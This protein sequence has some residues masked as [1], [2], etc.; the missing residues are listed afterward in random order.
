MIMIKHARTH[1]HART[2]ARAHARTPAHTSFI[3]S[4][5]PKIAN[6]ISLSQGS[7]KIPLCRE[8]AV[9]M[10]DLSYHTSVNNL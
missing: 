4:L 8:K 3:K 5:W 10:T 1:T 6:N 2:H 7:R 9:L